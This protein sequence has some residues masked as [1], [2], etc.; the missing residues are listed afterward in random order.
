MDALPLMFFFLA[1][2]FVCLLVLLFKM[3]GKIYECEWKIGELSAQTDK[4][5]KLLRLYGRR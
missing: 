3:V 1:A 4:L 5:E 2:A